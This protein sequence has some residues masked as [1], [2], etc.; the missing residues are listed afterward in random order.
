MANLHVSDGST[1]DDLSRHFPV[2]A[3]VKQAL[4]LAKTLMAEKEGETE[5]NKS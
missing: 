5:K 3:I 2:Q 4:K 1:I